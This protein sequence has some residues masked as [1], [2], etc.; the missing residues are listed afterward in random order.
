MVELRDLRGVVAH[1]SSVWRHLRGLGPTHKKDL[2]AVEQ[3]RPDVALARQTWIGERQ[4]FMR[5]MALLHNSD[6]GRFTLGLH[7]VRQAA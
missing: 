6:H 4:P 5:N 3:K 7:T 1:R 2:R